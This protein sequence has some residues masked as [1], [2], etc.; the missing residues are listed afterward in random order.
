MFDDTYETRSEYNL[1]RHVFS[2]MNNLLQYIMLFCRW[3]NFPHRPTHI[4]QY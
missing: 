4:Y 3:P 1:F 2:E